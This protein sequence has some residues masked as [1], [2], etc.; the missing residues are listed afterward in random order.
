MSE[1]ENLQS[2]LKQAG[3][4]RSV[5]Q[6]FIEAG[7]KHRT[8]SKFSG[9]AWLHTEENWPLCQH[10]Q[11][12]MQM[13]LQLNCA[14]LP[15]E[16]QTIAGTGLIQ[17]FYC[18]NTDPFCAI[19]CEA[20]YPFAKSVLARRVLP[21]GE[22]A[23]YVLPEKSFP[24][25]RIIGWEAGSEEYPS[26]E[27]AMDLLAEQDAVL[28]DGEYD[29]LLEELGPAA[30]EKLGGWPAWAQGV[31]YPSCPHC[32]V[33]MQVIFQLDSDQ[34]LPHSWG[35]MGMGHLSVCKKHPDILAFGWA[36]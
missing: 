14:D 21:D 3:L 4:S 10:C 20:W 5:W 22:G 27:E 25:K 30:G 1:L 17:L 18:I 15:A 7:E 29:L 2:K 35:D 12:P 6:P 36:C 33:P 11:T 9:K 19:D 28:S 32:K 16:M 34:N 23:E 8:E 31:E 26:P 24:A 13:M